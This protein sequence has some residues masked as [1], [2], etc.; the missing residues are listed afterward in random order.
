MSS[1]AASVADTDVGVGEGLAAGVVEADVDPPGEIP[2]LGW[3]AGAEQAATR[4]AAAA[5]PNQARIGKVS[6][7]TLLNPRS[8]DAPLRVVAE[9]ECGGK[10]AFRLPDVDGPSGLIDDRCLWDRDQSD[11]PSL[12]RSRQGR[13]DVPHDDERPNGMLLVRLHLSEVVQPAVASRALRRRVMLQGADVAYLVDA[14]E[15]SQVLT[16][17]RVSP[18]FGL[19]K[20]WRQRLWSSCHRR[21]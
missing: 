16:S 11:D 8:D 10:V 13:G 15:D 18:R 5:A 6:L 3:L 20:P 2:E 12:V 21:A 9:E 19:R 14:V 4:S 1:I 17:K 7:A